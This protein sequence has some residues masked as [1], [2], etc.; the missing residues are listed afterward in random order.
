MGS[1]Q[2]TFVED[3]TFYHICRYNSLHYEALSLGETVQTSNLFNPMRQ[4]WEIGR[5]S[6]SNPRKAAESYWRFTKEQIF[7]ETRISVDPELPSRFQSIWLS[8]REN[9]KYWTDLLLN[10]T[11]KDESKKV[12]SVFKVAVTGKI[13]AGDAHWIETGNDTLPLKDIREKAMRYWSGEI[14]RL[15]HMEFLLEGKMKVVGEF[16]F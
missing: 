1:T 10:T 9:L 2:L 5:T 7:E 14:F 8:D 16:K 11:E 6:I 4:S 12:T 13:F 3:H 15:G